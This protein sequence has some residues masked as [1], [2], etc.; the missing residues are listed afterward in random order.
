MKKL[1][2][3]LLQKNYYDLAGTDLHHDKHLQVLT[4][5]IQNGRLFSKIGHVGFK[6]KE[7]F[8]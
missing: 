4:Q 2:E 3:Y 1:A 5:E 8:F 6:N 7:L